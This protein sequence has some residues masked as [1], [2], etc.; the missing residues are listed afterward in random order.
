MRS[1]LGKQRMTNNYEIL[2]PEDMKEWA[3]PY[4]VFVDSLNPMCCTQLADG[5]FHVYKS[6]EPV[7]LLSGSDFILVKEPVFSI[8][9]N[10]CEN[11]AAFKDAVVMQTVKG[12]NWGGYY[13][14]VPHEEIFPD[15]IES[16]DH[17]GLKL[18]HFDKKYLFVSLAVKKELS[19][20]N[21]KGVSFAPGFYGFA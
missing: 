9:R 4:Y 21:I 15:T 16:I 17:S 2:I 11:R 10:L 18:W 3:G 5:R 13:E 14:I 1:M 8:L 19:G 20:S 6:G 7:I 12:E